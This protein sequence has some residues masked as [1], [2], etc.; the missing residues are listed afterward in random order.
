MTPKR[1]AAVLKHGILDSYVVPWASKVGST[2]S[3]KAVAV[4]DGYAGPGTYED[5]TEGS[6][7][8]LIRSARSVARYRAI[9]LHFVEKARKHSRRLEVFL[10][11]EAVALD[12]RPYLGTVQEHLPTILTA[13][14]NVPLFAYLLPPEEVVA[15]S[16][17]SEG[18]WSARQPGG[19]RE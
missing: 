19:C 2:A 11:H 8:L 16:V 5:G 13:T 3:G 1:A 17:V 12:A 14:R 4:L 10:E 7:A 15:V 9:Q 6:P 18:F